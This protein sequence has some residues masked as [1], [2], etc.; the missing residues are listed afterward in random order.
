M[1]ANCQNSGVL[2]KN[3]EFY[4]L[5]PTTSQHPRY[6]H[7]NALFTQSGF[8]K[9]TKEVVPRSYPCSVLMEEEKK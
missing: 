8:Q 9:S 5:F 2:G 7:K 3:K 6:G 4:I 1:L